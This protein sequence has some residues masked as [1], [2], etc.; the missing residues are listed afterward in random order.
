MQYHFEYCELKLNKV[1]LQLLEKLENSKLIFLLP[2][3]L[4]RLG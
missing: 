2:T 1:N 4:G 3:R